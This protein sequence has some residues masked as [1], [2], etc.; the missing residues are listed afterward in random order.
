MEHP[1][2]T[3]NPEE[4]LDFWFVTTPASKRYA[5][6]PEFD[7]EI[8]ARFLETWNEGRAGRWP[9]GRL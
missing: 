1:I 9:S 7:A 6:D 8:R 2:L 5:S 3:I 4:I